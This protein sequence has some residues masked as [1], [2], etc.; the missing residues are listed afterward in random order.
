[1]SSI[2]HTVTLAGEAATL[3]LGAAVAATLRPGMR[4]YLE[5]DLGAGKT[6]FSRGLVRA[7]GHTGN[8]RSPTYT[9]V[10]IYVFSGYILYHFDF[11]RFNDPDEWHES[12]LDEHFNEQSVCLV[13]WPDKAGGLLPK[14]D[15]E[16]RFEIAEDGLS[17]KVEL[18][19]S[20]EHGERCLD[21]LRALRPT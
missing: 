16:V 13:E 9:L 7:L 4:V 14:P 5:G 10:E 12:G 1:M 11:Y 17:R 15:V 8:V 21:A 3:A 2:H 19:A 6:T 18:I 20:S